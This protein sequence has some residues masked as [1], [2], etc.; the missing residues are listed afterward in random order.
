MY[1]GL[2]AKRTW[3]VRWLNQEKQGWNRWKY[4][5]Y[6]ATERRQKETS[7]WMKTLWVEN[8]F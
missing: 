3:T 7:E 4:D 1:Q 5:K 6:G 2:Y 8:M